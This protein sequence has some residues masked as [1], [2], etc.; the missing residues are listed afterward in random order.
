LRTNPTPRHDLTRIG[1]DR[2]AAA[3][4]EHRAQLLLGAGR[5]ELRLVLKLEQELQRA[6]QAKLLVQPPV[7]RRFHALRA[8]RMAATAV[9]PVLRTQP[10]GGCALLQQQLSLVVEDQ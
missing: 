2:V 5:L 9:R 1:P 4:Y 6:A 8:P 7:N 10:L 3:A